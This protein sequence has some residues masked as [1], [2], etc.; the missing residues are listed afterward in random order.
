MHTNADLPTIR[1]LRRS[2]PPISNGH[3]AATE[4]VLAAGLDNLA[5][6]IEAIAARLETSHL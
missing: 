6:R 4:G 5:Q 2:A 1:R 3:D